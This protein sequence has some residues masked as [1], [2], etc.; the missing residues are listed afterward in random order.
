MRKQKHKAYLHVPDSLFLCH[1]PTTQLHVLGFHYLSVLVHA[2]QG[3]WSQ[4][5]ENMDSRN[6]DRYFHWGNRWEC[7]EKRIDKGNIVALPLAYCAKNGTSKHS[8]WK[9]HPMTSNIL[10]MLVCRF[11]IW[12]DFIPWSHIIA[13][14]PIHEFLMEIVIKHNH[15]I[16]E[17]GDNQATSPLRAACVFPQSVLS[18]SCGALLCRLS[19]H[20]HRIKMYKIFHDADG[21]HDHAS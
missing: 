6:E 15:Q 10:V 13:C 3:I 2:G 17:A 11:E 19:Q 21:Y 20:S 1:Q 12:K 14:H 8:K 5:N 4:R 7:I 9:K 16:S 18:G